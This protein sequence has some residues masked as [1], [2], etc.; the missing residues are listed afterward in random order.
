MNASFTTIQNSLE[1]QEKSLVTEQYDI[2]AGKEA[3]EKEELML[4]VD[5]QNRITEDL[6]T[7][8]GDFENKTSIAFEDLLNKEIK[9]VLNEDYYTKIQNF[10]TTNTDLENLYHSKKAL[11]LKIVGIIR[12]KKEYPSDLSTPSLVYTDKL[13]NYVI[14]QNKNSSIVKDQRKKNYNV[15]TGERFDLNTQEGKEAKEQMLAFLGED[16]VPYSIQ[17]YPKDFSTKE[18]LLAYLD[19]YN[20][21]KEIDKQVFY[22]D[23][24]KMITSLSGNV[25]DAIAI[26]LVAFSA[27]SL[28]VSSI[29]IGIIMYISVLER[30]KEIGI[31]RSL[32]ARKKDISR[33]F[34][35]ETFIIGLSAG[36]LGIFITCFLLVLIN[37]ILY[38][39]TD[40]EN[41]AILNPLHAISLIFMSLFL[42]LIGGKIPAKIAS[43]KDPVVALRTE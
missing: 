11:T 39:L 6:L 7:N 31:L 27:I 25:M 8:L 30:T 23:Q 19:Q 42:T 43:K 1:K 2:L 22:V 12:L 20:E 5:S 38:Q 29:M 33:V 41:I 16:T 21:G 26:V 17:L 28:I 37:Q 40:I 9:L 18:K 32:G 24:A 14:E 36:I 35:A 15:L 10:Y 3:K 4:I 13:L 34:N